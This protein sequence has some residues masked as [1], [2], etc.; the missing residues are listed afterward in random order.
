L[1]QQRKR[2]AAVEVKQLTQHTKKQINHAF[3]RNTSPLKNENSVDWSL[4]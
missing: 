4:N 3:V 1:K 2:E